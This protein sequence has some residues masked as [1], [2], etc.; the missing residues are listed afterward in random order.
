MSQISSISEAH[1]SLEHSDFNTGKQ[2][3]LTKQLCL[4]YLGVGLYPLAVFSLQPRVLAQH[5]FC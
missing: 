1:Y 4:N 2:Y 5:T 3:F